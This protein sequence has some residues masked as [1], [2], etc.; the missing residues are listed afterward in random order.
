MSFKSVLTFATAALA[1]SAVPSASNAAN[2]IND[3]SFETQGSAAT[4]Y[5]SPGN[6][7]GNNAG[8]CYFGEPNLLCGNPGAPW[9]GSGLIKPPSAFGV[10][11]LAQDG[12]IYSFIQNGQILSQSFM[13]TL[14]GIS[15]LSFWTAGRTNNGGAQTVNV[16]LNGSSVGIFTTSQSTPNWVQQFFPINLI[17]GSNTLEFKGQTFGT[18][19]DQTAFIDNISVP[20]VPEPSTWAMLVLGFGLIGFA[21]RRSQAVSTR[22]SF[23]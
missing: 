8:Y 5:S 15:T 16:F 7:V 20:A 23:A 10:P 4:F 12:K 22:V 19:V 21:L 3:G 14:A 17:A 6:P 13:S 1:L 18:G 2:I 9:S 11:D